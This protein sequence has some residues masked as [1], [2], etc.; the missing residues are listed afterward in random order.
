MM[1]KRYLLGT[2]LVGFIMIFSCKAR[3][4]SSDLLGTSTEGTCA[5]YAKGLLH[6][7][8]DN[9]D[10]NRKE[11]R[12]KPRTPPV[13]KDKCKPA[14]VNKLFYVYPDKDI[15]LRYFPYGGGCTD[16]STV[17]YKLADLS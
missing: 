12:H 4:D 8:V 14:S 3:K 1:L 7:C 9:I 15:E 13:T 11:E 2:L 6:S 5:L 16:K 10:S 17:K